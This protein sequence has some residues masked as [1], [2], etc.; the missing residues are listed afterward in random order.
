VG[1]KGLTV[2]LKVVPATGIPKPLHPI[3]VSLSTGAV[4]IAFAKLET[5]FAKKH[6]L[7]LRQWFQYRTERVFCKMAGQK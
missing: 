2:F 6:E 5:A 4:E 7:I 3:L 1:P